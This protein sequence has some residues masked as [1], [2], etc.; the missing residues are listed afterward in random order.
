MT[1]QNVT[2]ILKSG[3]KIIGLLE[4]MCHFSLIDEQCDEA[5]KGP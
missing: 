1:A 5:E 3:Y 4:K 2:E